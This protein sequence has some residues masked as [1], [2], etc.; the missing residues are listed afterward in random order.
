MATP[1]S[2]TSLLTAALVSVG[3]E[4][5]DVKEDILT[6][7]ILIYFKDSHIGQAINYEVFAAVNDN[8]EKIV[9]LASDIVKGRDEYIMDEGRKAIK[10]KVKSQAWRPWDVLDECEREERK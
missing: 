5:V 3:R 9:D 1:E 4:P 2:K 10:E 6:R 8:V 7:N